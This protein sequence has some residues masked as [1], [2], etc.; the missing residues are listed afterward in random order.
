[1]GTMPVHPHDSRYVDL[2]LVGRGGTADVY[3]AYDR[4]LSRRVAVKRFHSRFAGDRAV[5][6]RLREEVG[7]S[8]SIASPHVVAV[9]AFEEADPALVM[10]LMEKGDL[11]ARLHSH[12][13]LSVA[14]TRRISMAVLGALGAAH[15]AG[16]IHRDIKP[17][18]ILFTAEDGAKVS[19]FG[20]ARSVSVAGLAEAGRIVGTP[21]YLAPETIVAGLWDARCDLYA[22][23][24]TVYECLAGRPPFVGNDAATIL[25]AQ[26]EAEAPRLPDELRDLDPGLVALVEALMRKD[27]NERPQTAREALSLVEEDASVAAAAGT[28]VQTAAGRPSAGSRGSARAGTEVRLPANR[29][30]SR[31]GGDPEAVAC[32]TCGAMLPVAYPWCFACGRAQ[33][34]VRMVA[35]G[36]ATVVVTGP[37]RRGDKLDA[38]LRDRVLRV[39]RASGLSGERL[40]KAVPRLPFVLAA[41]VDTTGAATL[42]AALER[43]GVEAEGLPADSAAGRR[44]L[45]GA[46]G[47]ALVMAPRFYAILAGVSGGFVQLLIRMP[48]LGVVAGLGGLAFAVPVAATISYLRPLSR[49]LPASSPRPPEVDEVLTRVTSPLVHARMRSIAQAA[50]AAVAAAAA[51][52]GLIA[53]DRE[54]VADFAARAVSRAASLSLA[55]NDSREGLRAALDAGDATLAR[56]IESV[57][58]R[59]LERIGTTALQLHGLA[60]RLAALGLR[61]AG[62]AM[63]ELRREVLRLEDE[64]A[65]WRDL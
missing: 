10:E 45:G 5:L 25:R 42:V 1:M 49:P 50:A 54:L 14:H 43:E 55:L 32:P 29:P 31:P 64:Q 47:K 33:L 44:V 57:E 35:K 40:G 21:D 63:S 56:K 19:D 15:S 11:G 8:R 38:E 7:V 9:Y 48:A 46:V 52:P 53:E 13:P 6:A 2:E 60:L 34:G 65:A 51:D 3:A 62:D 20:L 37:G 22:L 27:P 36:G 18:N 59:V 16:V 39:S 28:E 4:A 17:R 41:K 12:G 61:R 30:V 24:C 58:H 26:V 23:G